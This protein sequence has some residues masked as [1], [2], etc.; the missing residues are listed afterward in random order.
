MKGHSEGLCGALRIPLRSR[1]EN[2]APS[3]GHTI[4]AAPALIPHSQS[5]TSTFTHATAA[6]NNTSPNAEEPSLVG[7]AVATFSYEY[8]FSKNMKK[9]KNVT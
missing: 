7:R 9:D 3:D 1:N 5:T 2:T 6:F 8:E 4:S